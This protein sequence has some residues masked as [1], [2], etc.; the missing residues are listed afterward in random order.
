MSPSAEVS[1]EGHWSKNFGALSI[2]RR[3]D[4]AVTVKGFNR[5]VWDF[6]GSSGSG[7]L[8]NV[9]GTFASHGSMLTA[10]SE[11][12]L[13]SHD[14]NN[15]WDWRKIPG[16]TTM[17]LT[18]RQ[19]RVRKARNFSPL[20]SAGG[21]TFKGPNRLPSGLFGMD[22]HQP[23]YEFSARSHPYP[24]IKLHFK[25]S[26]FFYQNLLVCLGSN[27]TIE[28]GGDTNAQTTLFQDKLVRDA[29]LFSIKVDDVTKDSSAPFEAMNPLSTNG[30]KNYTTLVD[31]KGNS[32]YIPGS[33][34]SNLRVHVKT[35]NSQTPAARPSSGVYATAWLEHTSPNGFYEYAIWINTESYPNIADKM[36]A[37]QTRET[38]IQ[39]P[40]QIIRQDDE[41]HVVRFNV[42][43]ESGKYRNRSE[44]CLIRNCSGPSELFGY[45]YFR[46]APSL[47][48]KGPIERV[49]MQCRIMA[50]E[51]PEFLYLSV[52]YPD[53]N[54]PFSK[55]IKS[56]SDIKVREL[57][58]MES[59]E[60]E[61]VVT[62]RGDF[63][64]CPPEVLKVFGSPPDYVPQIRVE[65]S[66]YP[67]A[68]PNRGNVIIFSNLK[69]GVSV[70]VK[71]RRG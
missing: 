3:K 56:F 21:V 62:L 28:D 64:K 27:I 57:F 31:T 44:E 9:F 25:K 33:S 67:Q 47:Y 45:V 32:Y 1:P 48:E 59:N 4:W 37:R 23:D 41:A 55:V 39:R 61:L 42:I 35:Q 20:S 43:P 60:M 66:A 6:E 34:A 5:F 26:V 12:A 10:S 70:E 53:L 14:V 19:I 52:S 54:F 13:K 51:F 17:S 15:G 24:N 7:K 36:W 18:L 46:S 38:G 16:A 8:E 50:E 69:N 2:H 30:K 49:N 58:Q 71:L 22:F 63:L 40:Y 11:E 68:D 29:S 65:S